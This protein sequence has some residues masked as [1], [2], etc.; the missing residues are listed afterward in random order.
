MSRLSALAAASLVGVAVPFS[1]ACN[2]SLWSR[3]SLASCTV[4]GLNVHA[5]LWRGPDRMLFVQLADGEE[6]LLNLHQQTVG[7]PNGNK[8][9]TVL[10][11]SFTWEG[12]PPTVPM[13][14]AKIEVD[15]RLSVS[16]GRIE[17]RS[18]QNKPIVLLFEE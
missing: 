8:M 18:V 4:S 3:V 14:F 6:Y 2:A 12:V 1:L 13:P 7:V 11:L 9:K 10:G 5:E 15:P 17:F 16:A